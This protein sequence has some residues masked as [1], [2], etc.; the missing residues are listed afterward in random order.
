MRKYKDLNSTLKNCKKKK[1]K[2]RLLTETHDN[3][4]KEPWGN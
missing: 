1:K 2:V 3:K 4:Q